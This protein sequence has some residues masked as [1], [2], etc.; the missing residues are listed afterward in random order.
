M[1]LHFIASEQPMSLSDLMDFF[2]GISGMFLMLLQHNRSLRLFFK[3]SG[4]HL[5]HQKPPHFEAPARSDTLERTTS[6]A[7]TLNSMT[8]A[9]ILSGDR[10]CRCFLIQKTSETHSKNHMRHTLI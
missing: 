6:S 5:P 10:L 7:K 1:Q 4:H 2:L 3:I 8:E 9:P